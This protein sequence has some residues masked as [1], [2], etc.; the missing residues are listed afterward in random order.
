MRY[1]SGKQL[2]RTIRASVC[3]RLERLEGRVLMAAAP[4]MLAPPAG[5]TLLDP[6]TVPQFVN[7]ITPAGSFFDEF[8]YDLVNNHVT[9]GAYP[10]NDADLGLGPDPVTNAPRLTD[11]FGYGTSPDT[12]S[13][14]GRSFVVREN[15]SSVSDTGIAVT[16]VNGLPDRHVVNID[17]TLLDGAGEGYPAPAS[18]Y[19][20]ATN[21]IP[22]GIPAVPHLHGGHT[23]AVYDGTPMQWWN[24]L[25]AGTASVG[26]DYV[27]TQGY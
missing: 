5:T 14:P 9:V 17:P 20:G 4:P 12:A 22:G 21:S 2:R 13:Y 1:E 8:R 24:R 10:I 19:D 18:V 7:D 16:W 25:E 11:L 6:F 26:Q 15:T 27:D 3:H 23:D